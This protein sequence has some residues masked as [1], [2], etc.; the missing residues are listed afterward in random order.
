MRF[1]K[2][3][4]FLFL[5]TIIISTLFINCSKEDSP[6]EPNNNAP[7]AT[8]NTPLDNAIYF[9]SDT[10]LFTATATD[11]ED[12]ALTDSSLVW[13][14]H[15][16]GQIGVGDSLLYSSL[17]ENT[18]QIF[19]TAT[20]SKGDTDI[21]TITVTIQANLPIVTIMSPADSSTFSFGDTI[22]FIGTAIDREDGVLTG[23][24]LVWTSD[25]DGQIGTGTSFKINTLSNGSHAITLTATDSHSNVGIKTISV[26]IHAPIT[27]EKTFGGATNNYGSS[28]LETSDGNFIGT[29]LKY[30]GGINGDDVYVFK[31][32]EKG[33]LLWEKTYGATDINF[34]NSIIETPDGNFLILGMNSFPSDPNYIYLIKIDGNGSLLWEK[35]FGGPSIYIG[36]SLCNTSDGN[37][38]ITGNTSLTLGGGPS[39]V[40]LLKIDNNGILLW[41]KTFGGTGVDV[42]Y[43]V[44][45]VS[46]G[47]YVITGYT[48]SFG[49]GMSDVYLIKTDINGTL[50]WEKT[51]GDIDT[52]EGFS[53]VETFD[54]GFIIAGVTYSFG[55]GS[56]DIYLIK[57][58]NSGNLVWQK[59][60]GGASWDIA[61]SVKQI[62]TSGFIIT[63]IT[64]SIGAGNYDLDIIKTDNNGILI[65]QKTFGGINDDGGIEISE[66]SDGG[67]IITGHTS[68]NT[69]KDVYLVKTDSLGNVY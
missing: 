13:S 57:V 3:R 18:H 4:L 56:A 42:G 68:S 50:V 19:L 62:S 28:V 8:I 25:K 63:G 21:D 65:S 6:T 33:T 16:N 32:D 14:S 5:T 7:V 53:V 20:D 41:Q 11:A 54:G 64:E 15:I 69:E 44:S 60:F 49:F 55:A 48:N 51:F 46:D 22:T 38:I 47:G 17:Y 9:K 34:G 66:T 27:F 58:D 1:S 35:K 29:G 2:L 43:S 24:S 52:D 59:T 45:E 39:D 61:Y 10:I 40:S 26:T 31:T 37:F 36:F 30:M 67:V 23:G 12:G